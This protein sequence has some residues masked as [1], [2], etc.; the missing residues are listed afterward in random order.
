VLIKEASLMRP[1]GREP[2]D[3]AEQRVPAPQSV[4]PGECG[5]VLIK[6]AVGD[7]AIRP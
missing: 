7:A 5:S 2:T 4:R 6:E 1:S 3:D